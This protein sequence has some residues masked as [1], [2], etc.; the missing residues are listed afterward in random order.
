MLYRLYFSLITAVLEKY[1]YNKIQSRYTHEHII[2][3]LNLTYISQCNWS[4]D[5]VK[6]NAV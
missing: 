1:K 5:Y 4:N 6:G 2:I 3:I